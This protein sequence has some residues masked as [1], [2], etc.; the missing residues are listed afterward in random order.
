MG[1]W[2]KFFA[3]YKPK[4]AYTKPGLLIVGPISQLKEEAH[5]KQREGGWWSMIWKDLEK[6]SSHALHIFSTL[7]ISILSLKKF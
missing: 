5:Q 6:F 2:G 7:G 3:I 1:V 4:E